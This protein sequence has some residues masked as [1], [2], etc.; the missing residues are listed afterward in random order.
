MYF[1]PNTNAHN[2][3]AHLRKW[4]KCWKICQ[5][6][7]ALELQAH[8]TLQVYFCY[9]VV[10]ACPDAE[11]SAD[12]FVILCSIGEDFNVYPVLEC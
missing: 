12:C 1:N 5:V 2:C 8:I 11:R 3:T 10:K 9:Q 4:S 6:L 7:C